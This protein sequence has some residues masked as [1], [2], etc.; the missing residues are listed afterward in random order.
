MFVFKAGVLILVNGKYVLDNIRLK[1]HLM[2]R[3]REA[4]MMDTFRSQ[5]FSFLRTSP[6][7][8][9]GGR[10]GLFG[11]NAVGFSIYY[12]CISYIYLLYRIIV[13]AFDG[14]LDPDGPRCPI[15]K[16][17]TTF[18]KVNF[19]FYFGARRTK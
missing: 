17:N 15:S 14:F 10:G 4:A 16:S 5:A 6:L 1:V 3:P 19:S 8:G 7:L 13:V 12:P 9:R 11:M 2:Q 18:N